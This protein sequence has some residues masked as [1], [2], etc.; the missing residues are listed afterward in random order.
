MGL[1]AG[2]VRYFVY[3]LVGTMSTMQGPLSTGQSLIQR[4]GLHQAVADRL[5]EAI[6][7][8]EL[9]AGTRLNERLLCEQLGVSRTPMREAFKVLAGEGLIRL[10]PNRGAVVPQM[11]IDEVVQA[12]EV[13]AALE[14]LSG[15]LAAERATPAQIKKLLK[16]QADMEQAHAA[17]NLSRYYALN[18]QIHSLINLAADNPVLQETY[19]TVNAR[20]QALRFRSN[21]DKT[22]W[23]KA[24]KEHALIAKA[25][26]KRDA[27][28]LAELLAA[29]VTAKCEIVVR[30]LEADQ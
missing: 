20:L 14:S 18:A 5:R 12:F 4:R 15:R 10:L 28:R 25:F 17:A 11:T 23:D 30:L 13:I 19:A 29:H 24:V 6:V 9:A 1:G 22:K 26:A 27:D 2:N 16:L 3:K 8:G 7:E 21:L